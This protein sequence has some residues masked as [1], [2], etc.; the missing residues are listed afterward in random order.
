MKKRHKKI[1]SSQLVIFLCLRLFAST[2]GSLPNLTIRKLKIG[3]ILNG[4]FAVLILAKVLDISVA[5]VTEVHL[6]NIVTIKLF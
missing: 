5:Q 6:K 3:R 1:T 4:C 2:S